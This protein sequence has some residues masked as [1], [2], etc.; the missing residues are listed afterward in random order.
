M[1]KY[2]NTSANITVIEAP[3]EVAG[4]SVETDER[5]QIGKPETVSITTI[6]KMEIEP[7]MDFG[8]ADITVISGKAK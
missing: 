8:E 3:Q 1:E 5:F 4:F 6:D 7:Q 2:P